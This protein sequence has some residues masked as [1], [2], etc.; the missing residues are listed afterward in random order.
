[1]SVGAFAVVAAR[2]RELGVPVTF[3][4]MAGFGWE[5]PLL[6]IAMWAFMLGFAGFPLTGGFVGK[7]YVFAAAYEHGWTWLVIVGVLA[8]LVSLYYYLG[9]VRAMVTLHPATTTIHRSI[10]ESEC[11]PCP[12]TRASAPWS[13]IL[14]MGS[15]N[16]CVSL[17]PG[18]LEDVFASDVSGVDCVEVRL[19]YLK[20]PNQAKDARWDRLPVPVIAT[21]RG[22]AHGGLFNGTIED[23]IRILEAAARNGARYVD[24]DYRY[25]RPVPPADVIASYHNF[26][27]T[28]PDLTD[29]V[30][31]VSRAMRR[32][33]R[34]PPRSIDGPITGGCWMRWPARIQSR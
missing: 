7:F 32:S 10:W 1:M 26:E 16:L 19:D 21:C 9:L 3:E 28:P 31:R 17:T 27:E 25:A 4:N 6:G 29:I 34:S 22:K 24:I 11:S 23:E 2:E 5:R 13:T 8:T 18:S 12:V 30:D 15:Q 20:D 14:E 33:R